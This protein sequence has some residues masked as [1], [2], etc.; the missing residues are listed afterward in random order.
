MGLHSGAMT[1]PN[2]QKAQRALH[3]WAERELLRTLAKLYDGIRLGRELP[4]DPWADTQ[5]Q[6]RR[7]DEG[8][9]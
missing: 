4:A 1:Q 3:W 8:T 2:D 7:D 9:E 6:V 5:P